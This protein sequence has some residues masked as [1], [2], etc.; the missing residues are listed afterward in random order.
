MPDSDRKNLLLEAVFRMFDELFSGR[1]LPFDAEAAMAYA[2]IPATRRRAGRPIS[3]FDAQIAAIVRSREGQLRTRQ[4][5]AAGD[6]FG[7]SG[8][9]SRDRCFLQKNI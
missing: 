2:R 5:T 7:K 3:Q 4:A 9:A 6:A 8:C 1:V